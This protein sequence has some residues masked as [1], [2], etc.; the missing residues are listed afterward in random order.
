VTSSP[1]LL[2][3]RYHQRLTAIDKHDC[4]G[5]R[6]TVRYA[7]RSNA[8][9]PS[10]SNAVHVL[11]LERKPISSPWIRWTCIVYA[12]SRRESRHL[13]GDGHKLID[14]RE[15]CDSAKREILLEMR[16]TH[17]RA[18]DFTCSMNQCKYITIGS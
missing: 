7:R 16:S 12:D 4:A 11:T 10:R 15:I 1:R 13:V 14:K 8:S 18:F 9:R 2:R 17:L 6:C 5:R 3:V